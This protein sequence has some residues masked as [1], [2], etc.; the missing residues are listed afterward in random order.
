M[1]KNC[2]CVS[3]LTLSTFHLWGRFQ[4]MSSFKVR[5]ANEQVNVEVDAAQGPDLGAMMAELR[6]Q[7]EGIARKNKEEAETWYLKKV[8]SS[9]SGLP[10][11]AAVLHIV[12]VRSWR[13]CSRRSRKATRLCDAPK[14]NSGRGDVSCRLWK[15]SSTVFANRY[16]WHRVNLAHSCFAANEELLQ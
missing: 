4:E 13:P 9:P 3:H 14:V 6:V 8:S 1:C 2:K 11:F 5:L 16:G 10:P 15:L 12:F 7:Y